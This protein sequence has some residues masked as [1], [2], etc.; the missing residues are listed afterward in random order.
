VN[1]SN[2]LPEITRRLREALSPVAIY[3]YGSHAYGRPSADSDVDLLVIVAD[4]AMDFFTRSAMAH[5]A[6]RG[7]GV[8]VDVQV[9]TQREFEE[10]ATLPVSFERTVRTKGQLLYAA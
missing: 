10:R 6:L 1:I 8:A 9:Y 7:I 2:L 3:L 5:R 4:S